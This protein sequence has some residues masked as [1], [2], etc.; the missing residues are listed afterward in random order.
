[1]QPAHARFL[2]GCSRAIG[3]APVHGGPSHVKLLSRVLVAV[4]ATLT[5]V[6]VSPRGPA[7]AGVGARSGAAAAAAPTPAR[8]W[9]SLRYVPSRYTPPRGPRFNN[10]Y[11]RSTDRRRILTHVI[12]TIDSVPGYRLRK[13]NGKPIINP[14]TGKR[15]V[16]PEGTPG[17]YPAQV[18]IA[19]YSIADRSFTDALIRAHRR[20]VSVK[21]LMNSHLNAKT[22]PS[23]ARLHTALG[24][25]PGNPAKYERD[26]SFAYR[27]SHGCLGSAVLHTKMYLFSS[28]YRARH[29]TMTGSSN[30]TSN[31]VHVQWNDLYTIRDNSKVYND[32]PSQFMRMVPD[33]TNGKPRVVR[34]GSSSSTFSPFFGATRSTAL[35]LNALNSIRCGG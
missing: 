19:L 24:G 23:W 34:G 22:S 7:T 26:R 4:A 29:V 5:L 3:L 16:C 17:L 35:T 15:A 25:R 13:N 18:K 8:F 12:R 1:M 32:Y 14:M 11:G 20:C 28:V 27:C 10:P 9:A 30:M 21:I 33:H 6:L 31:A 2:P